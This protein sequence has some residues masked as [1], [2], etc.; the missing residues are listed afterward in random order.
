[1]YHSITTSSLLRRQIEL[2]DN[3]YA[4]NVLGNVRIELMKYLVNFC[5]IENINQSRRVGME[6]Q[7]GSIFTDTAPYD[8]PHG[9]CLALGSEYKMELH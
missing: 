8:H 6:G 3:R 4:S 2:M 5:G 7:N 1:L 9:Y